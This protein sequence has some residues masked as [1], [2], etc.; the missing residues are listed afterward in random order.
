MLNVIIVLL[1]LAAI[2]FAVR[3]SILHFKGQGACCGGGSGETIAVEKT[4]EGNVVCEKTAAV[5]GMVCKNCAAHV[6]NAL[7]ALEG[8]S[9]KV[10]LKKA[11]V[12]IRAVRD[13]SDEEI[14]KAVSDAGYGVGK[15][16]DR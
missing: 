6:Q 9:A 4:L 15:I 11:E 10:N 1:I 5:E 12:Q 3:S 13:V 8:V 16:I 2:V 14:R 7:N